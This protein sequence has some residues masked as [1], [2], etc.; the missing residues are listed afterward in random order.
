M[1]DQRRVG[2]P[3]VHA[4]RAV[5]E[6]PAA[7]RIGLVVAPDEF[8]QRRVAD[9][10]SLDQP[11]SAPVEREPAVDRRHVRPLREAARDDLVH[12][13]TI[14]CERSE[15]EKPAENQEEE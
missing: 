3:Y 11:V 12:A 2:E 8:A 7:A 15:E 9:L 14:A 13:A 6:K 1:H 10:L 4:L 5:L